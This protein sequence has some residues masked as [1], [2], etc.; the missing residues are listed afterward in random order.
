MSDKWPLR[1]SA[2]I[3]AGEQRTAAVHMSTA[4]GA[5]EPA[6]THSAI[7]GGRVLSSAQKQ[8]ATAQRPFA[9][10][11]IDGTLIRWQLFH[12]V[13]DALARLGYLDKAF[14]NDIRQARRDWKMRAHP[15]SFKTY[16]GVMIQGFEKIIAKISVDQFESA[17][18][19]VIQE[20]K[21]QIYIYSK[22]LIA[23][24]K[25]QNYVLFAISGSQ[26]ELVSR[27]ASYYGFHDYAGT[28]YIKKDGKFTGEKIFYAHDKKAVL[29]RLIQK[30]GVTI[31]GSIAIGDSSSDIP[32]LEMADSPIAFNPEK[33][34]YDVARKSGWTI[35]VERK[36][37]FYKLESRD[38]TYILA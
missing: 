20:Y 27:I 17:V 12:A 8:A 6:T 9:V 37:T 5:A 22:E 4:K 35:V 38:G 31:Q 11:D 16:E 2:V 19:M 24:L 29:E 10:F 34:L 32:M 23:E 26:N 3:G 14:Y 28:E 21:D 30:H 33:K 1:L 7:S 36:N 18:D 13:T 25:S 15:E